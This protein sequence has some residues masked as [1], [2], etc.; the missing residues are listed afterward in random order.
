MTWETSSQSSPRTT[1]G[2]IVEY[3]PTLHDSGTTALDATIAVGWMLTPSLPPPGHSALRAIRSA[4]ARSGC[5]RSFL[6]LTRNDRTHD[7]RLT[8]QLAVDEGLAF[9]LDRALAPVEHLD[10]DP[11]LIAGDDRTGEIWRV[12]CR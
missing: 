6:R 3:G 11:Q 9:H 10:F 2:P 8:R 4:A 12:R 7:D 1:L 5:S